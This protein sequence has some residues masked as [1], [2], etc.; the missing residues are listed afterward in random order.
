MGASAVFA[1]APKWKRRATHQS[2]Q[3]SNLPDADGSADEAASMV[4]ISTLITQEREKIVN[5]LKKAWTKPDV[6]QLSEVEIRA[7]GR[8]HKGVAEMLKTSAPRRAHAA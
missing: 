6:R 8:Q 4:C 3:S 7:L 5:A 2:T 1:L